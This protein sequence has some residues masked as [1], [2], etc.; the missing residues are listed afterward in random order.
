LNT[1]INKTAKCFLGKWGKKI[2]CFQAVI[3]QPGRQKKLYRSHRLVVLPDFQGIGIG[4]LFQ[5]FVAQYTIK[6]GYRFTAVTSNPALIFHRN[7]NPHWK[8]KYI[9]KNKKFSGIQEKRF[10]NPKRITTSW[11]YINETG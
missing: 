10:G 4:S 1:E 11:E 5:E 2:I 8:L 6:Q 7:K 9:Y 3:A